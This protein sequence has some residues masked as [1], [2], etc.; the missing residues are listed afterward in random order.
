MKIPAWPSEANRAQGAPPLQGAGRSRPLQGLPRAAVVVAAI[1]FLFFLALGRAGQQAG[2]TGQTA[3]PAPGPVAVEEEKPDAEAPAAATYIGSETCQ[4]CHE[5][6][7]NSFMRTNAH[8]TLE[9]GVARPKWKGQAC[10]FCHGPGSVHAETVSAEDILNPATAS[11]T[12]E[13]QTCLQCHRNQR[14]SAGRLEGGHGRGQ[15]RCSTCHPVHSEERAMVA[16]QF[17]AQNEQCAGCHT[18]AWT[19][20]QRPH[21]HRL[22]EGSMSC[23]SCH[24]PHGSVRRNM[25]RTVNANE[26]GCFKCHGDKRGPFAFEHAPMRVDGCSTCHEPHGSANPRMLTR[27]EQRFVCMECHSNVGMAQTI[28]GVPPA[29]HDLR[30]PRIQ[31]CTICHIKIHGS[32]VDR[33]L[34]R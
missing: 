15:V 11:F 28:G 3:A 34:R 16:R 20:F 32:H 33:A 9:T 18:A 31:N 7:F 1:F 23:V 25:V 21:K 2:G 8:R 26:P 22:P 5:D 24:N 29:F 30:N 6:I 10:E 19:E 13:N 17:P 27:H 14:T 4:A 12:R